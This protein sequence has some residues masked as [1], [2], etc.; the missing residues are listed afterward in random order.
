MAVH[1]GLQ[2]ET[3]LLNKGGGGGG[4]RWRLVRCALRDVTKGHFF[5][6]LCEEGVRG[7]VLL[8]LVTRASCIVLAY[9]PGRVQWLYFE[10]MLGVNQGDPFTLY[11]MKKEMCYERAVSTVHANR[12]C[13]R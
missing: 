5:I 4:A 7:G 2:P 9:F 11:E 1:A 6:R 3:T 12:T 8:L 10:A 13:M